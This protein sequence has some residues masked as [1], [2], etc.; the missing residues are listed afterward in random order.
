MKTNTIPFDWIPSARQAVSASLV[1]D[2]FLSRY[3]SSS[4]QPPL[5]SESGLFSVV[6]SL[7][8]PLFRACVFGAYRV[9]EVLF[10]APAS[11]SFVQPQTMVSKGLFLIPESR[12][13]TERII[14]GGPTA[15]ST[16][17]LRQ[18]GFPQEKIDNL[19]KPWFER[20]PPEGIDIVM[21][22]AGIRTLVHIE[23]PNLQ[24]PNLLEGLLAYYR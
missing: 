8:A 3:Q 6:S 16:A 10:L 14:A 20:L 2:S 23:S 22:I 1:P 4:D 13:F 21:E 19:F 7:A 12:D 18:M 5:S 11:S 24:T 9:P 17:L 15:E